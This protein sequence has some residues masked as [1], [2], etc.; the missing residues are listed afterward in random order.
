[1]IVDVFI[2]VLVALV[3]LNVWVTWRAIRDDLSTVP[4]RIVQVILV[5]VAPFVGALLVLH[6]QRQHPER[7]RGRYREALDAGDDLPTQGG[8]YGRTLRALDGDS[9]PD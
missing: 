3:V 8:S 9:A 2:A 4:Q 6:L 1:M 7:S 5:W